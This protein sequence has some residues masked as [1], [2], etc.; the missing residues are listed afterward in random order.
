MVRFFRDWC[1]SRQLEWGHRIPAYKAEIENNVEW[2]IARSKE[3]A[4]LIA[5]NKF[6][7]KVMLQQDN[8]VL[9]TWFSS[10][11][12]PF[13]IM[14][15]PNWVSNLF[16]ISKNKYVI[17]VIFMVQ[18]EDMQTHY[19]LTLLE[20]GNDILCFWVARMVMLGL[21][22]TGQLP[23]Q[24]GLNNSMFKHRFFLIINTFET[25]KHVTQVLIDCMYVI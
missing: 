18:N 11:L 17:A 20:T 15:W 2:I 19:P 10:A 14:G 23:F 21:E 3:E 4:E 12:L 22:L 9:D 6:R 5:F 7:T 24:V 1:V 25:V 16:F 8:D 13:S